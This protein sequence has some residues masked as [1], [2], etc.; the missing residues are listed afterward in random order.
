[1]EKYGKETEC[2]KTTE[3]VIDSR[4]PR[5]VLYPQGKILSTIGLIL[6]L[7]G[8]SVLFYYMFE[9]LYNYYC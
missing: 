9:S 1:M 5:K 3:I 6:L 4:H 8:G 2:K 7:T